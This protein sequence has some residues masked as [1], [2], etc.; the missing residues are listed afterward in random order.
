MATS[1]RI[2]ETELLEALAEATKG[3][4]DDA[5]TT[6]ELVE[7]TG[8]TRTTVTE[9]LR[10]LHRQGRLVVHQVKRQGFDGKYR[11]VSAYTILPAK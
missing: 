1:V 5:R 3:G 4:P 9:A 6:M 10:A 7:Q 8:Q 2:T 11:P